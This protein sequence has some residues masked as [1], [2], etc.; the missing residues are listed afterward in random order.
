VYDNDEHDDVPIYTVYYAKL[1]ICF[2]HCCG[3][4][5]SDKSPVND[6]LRFNRLVCSVY[7]LYII[8]IIMTNNIE[9]LYIET[10][11]TSAVGNYIM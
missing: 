6:N 8:Y 7:I 11:G 4:M 2:A 1:N 10:L 3:Y 9:P 5:W